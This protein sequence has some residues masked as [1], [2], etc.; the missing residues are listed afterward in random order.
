MILIMNRITINYFIMFKKKS[1]LPK[2][3]F[4]SSPY[5]LKSFK[6]SHFNKIKY[7]E[8][9]KKIKIK[10]RERI[11]TE[12]RSK[13]EEMEK[14][15]AEVEMS[16]A[17]V[18][19]S[20]ASLNAELSWKSEAMGIVARAERER[21]NVVAK[22]NDLNET[23]DRRFFLLLGCSFRKLGFTWK[24]VLKIYVGHERHWL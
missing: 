13:F 17:Q 22:I 21:R 16:R 14:L 2:Q 8:N 20:R 1:A 9:S 10:F 11:A 15:Y 19:V 18:E 3:W 6:I 4:H 24:C 23:L 7:I 12:Q 5:K